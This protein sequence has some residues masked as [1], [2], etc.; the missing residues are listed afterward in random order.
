MVAP[1]RRVPPCAS[2]WRGGGGPAGPGG[3]LGGGGQ[4]ASFRLLARPGGQGRRRVP[5]WG[6]GGNPD[7][8]PGGGA[9]A[10]LRGRRRL[11]GVRVP[12]GLRRRGEPAGG[13]REEETAARAR[14]RGRA[15]PLPALPPP[16]PS[17]LGPPP[18]GRSGRRSSSSGLGGGRRRA[19][20]A[21]GSWE[22]R[23]V[24][25]VGRGGRTPLSPAARA[26]GGGTGKGRA[27]LSHPP[28]HHID[29]GPGGLAESGDVCP[30]PLWGRED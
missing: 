23:A 13:R 10:A 5:E 28:T 7:P 15:R 22:L 11:R 9:A 17:S 30:P 25:R 24:S 29:S 27:V 19:L 16:P 3:W 21:R 18:G 8:V 14:S 26:G 20:A 12:A 2:G 1:L 4:A 6:G